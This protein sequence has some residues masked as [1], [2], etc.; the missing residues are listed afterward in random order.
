MTKKQIYLLLDSKSAPLARGVLETAPDGSV[1]Q[2]HILDGKEDEVAQHEVIQ[3]VGM[4]SGGLAVQ[5][6]LLRQRG[7]R[8]SLNKVASLGSEFRRN[9]RVPVKFQSFIYPLSGMWKGRGEV[10]SVDISCGGIA[11]YG[12]NGLENGETLEIVIPIT[13]KPMVLR[14]QI[15]RQQMLRNNRAFYAAKFVDMCNDEET[16]LREAVFRVQLEGRPRRS[17][18]GNGDMEVER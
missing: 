11:F 13:A 2:I 4:E 6:Q 9:L 10:Q 3:L 1:L 16:L 18:A 14:C 17:G 15:L 8:I 7:E 5:C 12:Q